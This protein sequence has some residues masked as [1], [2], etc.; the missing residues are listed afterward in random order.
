MR[1]SDR[2]G[3]ALKHK[4]RRAKVRVRRPYFLAID[5]L[6]G[7]LN[8]GA[9]IASVLTVGADPSGG[10]LYR[11][12]HGPIHSA[13]GLYRLAEAYV[14]NMGIRDF[15]VGAFADGGKVFLNGAENLIRHPV[16]TAVAALGT[17]AAFRVGRTL[18]DAVETVSIDRHVDRMHGDSPHE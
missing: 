5:A 14:T 9:S 13:R 3:V 17:Y 18:I 8:Y 12:T 16:E 11:M 15:T 4:W 10:L 6:K 1:M 7:G 2:F